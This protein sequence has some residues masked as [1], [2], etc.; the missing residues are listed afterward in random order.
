MFCDII[1]FEI[2]TYALILKTQFVSNTDFYSHHEWEMS[3]D[4]REQFFVDLSASVTQLKQQQQTEQQRAL[5]DLKTR[6][7]ATTVHIVELYIII[8]Q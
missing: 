3:R 2:E 4:L 6:F 8:K 1:I 7:S 5:T